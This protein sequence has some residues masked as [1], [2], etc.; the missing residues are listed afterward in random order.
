[1]IDAYEA[2]YRDLVTPHLVKDE[3]VDDRARDGRGGR[4][5]EALVATA[6]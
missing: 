3:P 1:M 2:V 4:A 5:A 6:G